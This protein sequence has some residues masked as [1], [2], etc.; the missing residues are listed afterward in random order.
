M[1]AG[2]NVDLVCEACGIKFRG[3]ASDARRFCSPKC[4]RSKA[5]TFAT[6]HG[7][8]RTRLYAIWLNMRRRC[9]MKS[10]PGFKYYGARGVRVCKE[11]DE[12]YEAFRTLALANGYQD[13]LEIERKR[14]R[15]NYEPGNCRWTTRLEQMRNTKK[16]CDAETSRFKGVSLHA[17]TKKWR[18]QYH[19]GGKP[20]HV[21]LFRYELEAA[22]AYD[23]AV[24][25]RFGPMSALNFPERISLL[26][27]RKEGVP[28]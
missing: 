25:D 4:S 18:T 7:D 2:G 24:F 20:V 6:T 23:Q 9:S 15:G 17:K 8:S 5:H 28:S 13:G 10:D 12:S 19:T 11:W 27:S 16:R 14:S 26:S 3:W 21:G 22:L 1:P